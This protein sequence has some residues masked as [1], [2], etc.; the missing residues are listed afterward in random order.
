QHW[1]PGRP[2]AAIV[3]YRALVQA[4]DCA[5]INALVTALG[6]AG[7]NPMPLYS[8]SLKDPAAAAFVEEALATFAPGVIINATGFSLASPG[9]QRGPTPFDGADCPIIQAVLSGGTKNIWD[10][11]MRGL[12]PRDIAMNVALPEVD[13]RILARAISFKSAKRWDEATQTNVV[14]HEPVPDRVAWTARLAAA[15]ARLRQ[16][17][18]GERRVAVV[19]ANYPNKDARIG[20]GVGLDTPASA[21]LVLKA[22]A[23][24]GYDVADVPSDGEALIT[25]LLA[26]P[27]N[28]LVRRR[29]KRSQAVLSLEAYREKF[30]E[31]PEDVRSSMTERWGDPDT[32]PHVA[33]GAFQL[34]IHRFG[35]VVV[36]VQPA[37]G[38]NIDPKATYHDPDLVPPHGYFAF[39]MWLTQE[40]DSHAVIH[41]GKHSNLEWLPG[42][43]LALSS[44]CFPEAAFAPVPHLY[45]FIVNDPGEGTQAKRRTSAVIIDHLTPP[46]ARAETYG[47]LR[48]LEALVDE[49]FEASQTDPRRLPIL[50][51][52]ILELCASTGLDQDC[53]IGAGDD[54]AEKLTKLDGYLCE[55]KEMQIRDGLHIFGASPDAGL[56]TSLLVALTRVPRGDGSGGDASLTRALAHDLTLGFDP[57]DPEMVAN[58][59]DARPDTLLALTQDPWRTTGDTVERLEL[60]ASALI[61]GSLACDPAWTATLDVLGEIETHLRP[62]VAACGEREL[63]GLM[64]GLDGRFVKPGPSGAP[65]RGRPDVLPTGRNFYSVDTR[66]VPTPAAWRLGWA[67]ATRLIERHAQDHGDWP[68]AVALSAWGTANMRTGG[69]DIAQ[70]LALMGVAP[71]W[72]PRS[73]RVTGFEIMPAGVLGRP[74]VDVTLRVSGFFRDAF[75][76]LIDLVD[77]AARA[78]MLLDEPA[79][80][81]PAAAR[82]RSEDG[83]HKG[84]RVF[85]SKPGAYGAGLQ[86]MIDERLWKDKADLA[87]AY[88]E[89]GGYA[90]GGGIEG[91]EAKEAFA[92]R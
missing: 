89:W 64:T 69:D 28:D 67:S 22:L 11:G 85:G 72:E 2:V 51:R 42:K 29:G 81:N 23:A 92:G 86:A 70:T 62:A 49:Y 31:L 55:L 61:D 9:A 36:G 41:L 56:E 20:N 91:D 6:D 10:D 59:S 84:A 8:Q 80:Q 48:D 76:G 79:D 58:W 35:K 38:Y 17:T 39:Y 88:L 4:G 26:G 83:V 90:Y 5:P 74:R 24:Q 82:Y 52:D 53:G 33:E 47:E 46:L 34:A 1:Q 66:A 73:G 32:D 75:P 18:M 40:F 12:A 57:L 37:R 13:G 68:R 27:T 19:M 60:L 54:E 25:Q 14:R 63:T 78:V 65:S 77:S 15:W 43:A 44:S 71:T 7:L 50:S 45:P 87:D 16:E 3:F 30:A 21:A